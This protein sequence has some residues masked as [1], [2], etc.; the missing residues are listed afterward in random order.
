MS[1]Q[2]RGSKTRQRWNGQAAV[3]M[4]LGSKAVDLL[5]VCKCIRGRPGTPKETIM[6]MSSQKMGSC[7]ML[8]MLRECRFLCRLFTLPL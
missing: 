7:L 6:S 8:M 1:G 2:H 5:W 4:A 3:A